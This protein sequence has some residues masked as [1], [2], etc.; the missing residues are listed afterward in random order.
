MVVSSLKTDDDG[1]DEAPCE[2]D[3]RVPLFDGAS[4]EEGVA[5]LDEPVEWIAKVANWLRMSFAS[6]R[7]CS[8]TCRATRAGTAECFFLRTCD[9]LDPLA[10]GLS[11][12]YL[13]KCFDRLDGSEKVLSQP[14]VPHSNRTFSLVE[15]QWMSE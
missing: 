10:S 14:G 3:R 5:G 8:S 9:G 2:A 11:L 6:C 4:F 12:W 15:A 13:F 7:E 1:A